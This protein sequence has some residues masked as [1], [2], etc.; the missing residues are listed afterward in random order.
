MIRVK[1][2]GVLLLVASSDFSGF[3][4]K[5]YI[6]LD[7]VFLTTVQREKS[8]SYES[9]IKFKKNRK[10]NKSYEKITIGVQI[11]LNNFL[12]KQQYWFK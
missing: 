11:H 8:N 2:G 6:K 4:E 9:H 3:S 5:V 7:T 1:D 12:L 10:T